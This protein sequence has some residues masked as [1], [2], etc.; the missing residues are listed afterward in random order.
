VK[1]EI[2]LKFYKSQGFQASKEIPNY[3]LNGHS[4]LKM[5]F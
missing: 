1:N 5:E 4:A 2:A 3:Y